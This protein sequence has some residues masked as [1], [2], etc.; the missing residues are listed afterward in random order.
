MKNVA[1]LKSALKKKDS[2]TP[3]QKALLAQAENANGR[4]GIDKFYV[5][6]PKNLKTALSRL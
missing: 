2:L 4:L 6:L 5:S 3:A 1:Q